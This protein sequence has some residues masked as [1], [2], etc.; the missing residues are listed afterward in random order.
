MAAANQPEPVRSSFLGTFTLVLIAIAV[1]F[2]IDLFLVR[3]EQSESRAESARLF[4]DGQDLMRQGRAAGAARQFQAALSIARGNRD[5][6]IALAQA[7][8]ASGKLASAEEFVSDLLQRDSTD[9]S[10]N[11]IMARVLV[12]EGRI[13]EAT[14]YYHRAIYGRWKDDPARHRQEAGFELVDLLAKQDSKQELLAELLPLQESAPDDVETRL[15]IGNLFLTAG[16]PARAADVFRLIVRDRP[17]DAEAHM[18]L[19]QAEFAQGNY[20]SA[21]ADFL[22][23]LHLKPA[24]ETIR[25]RLDL[26]TRVLELDPTQRGLGLANRYRRSLKLLQMT[27]DEVEQCPE[28][29]H[30]EDLNEL[31]VSARKAVNQPVSAIRQNEA[32]ETNLDLAEQLWQS[33]KNKCEPAVKPPEDLALVLAKIAQ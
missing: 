25:K 29:A 33:A 14:S 26:T 23:A 22:A 13:P 27:L 28:A 18:G 24:D 20:R 21:G 31:A 9:G 19:G 17:Q 16:S 3:M 30:A 15:R 8:L 12:K 10:S 4:R 1:L 7:L 11:L 5:Y 6:Q 2:G 32:F